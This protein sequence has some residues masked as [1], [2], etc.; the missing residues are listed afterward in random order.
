MN[1]KNPTTE[2]RCA[3]NN[4]GGCC[5]SYWMEGPSCSPGG[6]L[7]ATVTVLTPPY[8]PATHE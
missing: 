2:A 1:D 8:E 5:Q 7:N 4:Y 6:A 3:V